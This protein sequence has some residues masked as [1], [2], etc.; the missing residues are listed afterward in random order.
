MI[1]KYL[2]KICG[3]TSSSLTFDKNKG[4]LHEDQYTL[5][6]IS[7]SFLRRMRNV[8]DKSCTENQNQCSMHI[9]FF[10]ASRTVYEIMWK[11]IGYG[12]AWQTTGDNI[13]WCMRFACWITKVTDIHS[14]YAILISF[15]GQQ[16]LC[17]GASVLRM[18]YNACLVLLTVGSRILIVL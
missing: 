13:T 18:Y 12:S 8:S 7:L 4:T 16:R 9:N 15:P 17:E 6:I 5:L 10:S 1:F 11:K 14:E 2:S 3:E